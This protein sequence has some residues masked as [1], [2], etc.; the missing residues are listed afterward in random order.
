MPNER[1]GPG[2]RPPSWSAPALL[3]GALGLV[4]P[5]CSPERATPARA[6]PAPEPP[7]LDADWTTDVDRLVLPSLTGVAESG[8]LVFHYRPGDLTEPQ[9]EEDIA[10]NL[11]YFHELEGKLDMAYAGRIHVFLYKDKADMRATTEGDADVAFSTGTVSVHQL[12][13]FRGVHEL[14]HI[15]ALQFPGNAD[16]AGPDLFLT[17]GLATAL[18]ES[19][20][21]VAVDAWAA[22][23]L[24]LGKLPELSALRADFMGAAPKGVHPYHVAASFVKSLIDRFGIEQVKAYY[25]NSTEAGMVFGVPLPRLERDWRERLAALAVSPA[26]ESHVLARFA[27]DLPPLPAEWRTKA[28]VTLFGVGAGPSLGALEPEDPSCWARRDGLLVGRHDGPWTALRSRE[29]FGPDVGLRVR[30]R[31]V[32]G[33][34]IKLSVNGGSEGLL[35]RWSAYLSVGEGFAGNEEVRVPEGVW[36]EA[37]LV[38]TGGRGRLFLNGLPVFDLEGALPLEPG[39]VGVAVEGAQVEFAEIAA[40]EP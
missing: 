3:L 27:K 30:F 21:G 39:S 34:A 15:F 8:A 24:R 5:A 37:I 32:S 22:M 36:C 18:A 20:Q 13:D 33:D 23:Y 14:T 7:A 40:F 2:R 31:L 38:S 10:A 25:E 19:D 11:A 28:G 4:P 12:H 6:T 26:D 16:G 1:P 17:E 35:T 29:R 9:L